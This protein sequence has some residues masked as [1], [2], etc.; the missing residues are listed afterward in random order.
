MN[1]QGNAWKTSNRF[2][3]DVNNFEE[4]NKIYGQYFNKNSPARFCVQVVNLPKDA[5]IEIEAIAIRVD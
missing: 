1:R 5:R 2:L 3:K 4:M